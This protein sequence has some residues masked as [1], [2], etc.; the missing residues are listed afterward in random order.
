MRAAAVVEGQ[1]SADAGPGFG[2]AGIGPQINL[3]VFDGP[4]QALDEDIVP[5]RTLA[6]HADLDLAGGQHLD[7]VGGCELAALIRVEDFGL[8]V[9]RQRFL[10]SF[11]AKISLQRDRQLSTKNP[12][13]PSRRCALTLNSSS[14]GHGERDIHASL[15]LFNQ[16]RGLCSSGVPSYFAILPGVLRQNLLHSAQHPSPGEPEA[17]PATRA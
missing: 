2:H 8:A 3:F 17:V 7:E 16:R 14:Q 5:P 6:V 12:C 10:H 15:H 9:L 4:P 13:N 11:Y 1:V